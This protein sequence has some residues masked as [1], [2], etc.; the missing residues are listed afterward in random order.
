MARGE[1]IL[2]QWNLLKTLQTRGIGMPLRDLA[3][4]FEVSERTI[5]RDF[6]MLQELGFPI[7]H[8]DD[9]VGKRYWK[10]PNDF[11]RSGPLVLSFTEAISLHLAEKL[12]HPLAGSHLDEG[13]RS[14]FEKIRSII[15]SRAMKYF[16]ELDETIYIRQSGV[17]DY[18]AHG[19]IISKLVD[20]AR[21][22]HT[23]EVDYKS[24]WKGESYSTGFDPYG[25]VYFE[26]DL[27]VV[28]MSHHAEDVR[29][30]KVIRIQ[31]V[32]P[33]AQ[34]FNRPE[35]FRMEDR[36]RST[37]GIFQKKGKAVEISVKFTG[38]V[39]QLIEE[40]VW[41]ETQR[42]NWL[43]PEATLFDRQP[44]DPDIL[45]ATF[46]LTDLIEFKRWIKGYGVHAEILKPAWLR[47][48]MRDELTRAAR[49]YGR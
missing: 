48:E 16:A 43:P 45:V 21:S 49:L 7:D 19:Q 39:A 28:G 40:R 24:L 47:K 25:L 36:F 46:R 6:E 34:S 37:F 31:H 18:S 44:E 13:M 5:Q 41:H 20:A 11:F 26:G 35:N 14:I 22:Q 8:E 1:Q 32:E 17:T 23:V 27:F 33:T 12:T 9:E 3:E 38:A 2:R 29:V 42:L 30:F 15:P 4:E 10:L